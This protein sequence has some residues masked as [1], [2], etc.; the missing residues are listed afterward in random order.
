M[1][2]GMKAVTDVPDISEVYLG[3][4]VYNGM[5]R[6][7]E[8]E[9]QL[10]MEAADKA[11]SRILSFADQTTSNIGTL[12]TYLLPGY[13][14]LVRKY[15]PFYNMLTK[16]VATGLTVNYNALTAYPAGSMLA[17][18]ASITSAAGTVVN[19]AVSVRFGYMQQTLSNIAAKIRS[20][21]DNFTQEWLNYGL[22]GLMQL[23]ESQLLTGDGTAPNMLGL[24]SMFDDATANNY[25]D[26][27]AASLT[28]DM[29]DDAIEGIMSYQ[30]PGAPL[31]ALTDAGTMKQLA[32]LLRPYRA[33]GEAY[34]WREEWATGIEYNGVRFAQHWAFEGKS[35]GSKQ[36]LIFNPD[37]LE[38]HE[39][40]PPVTEDLG[41]SQSTDGR[42]FRHKFYAALADLSA[43]DSTNND[44]TKPLAHALID[45]LA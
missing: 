15:A 9:K 16:K 13:Q 43:S 38:V 40:S 31:Y 37:F 12:P 24:V 21:V 1:E 18:G 2:I 20:G 41:I 44:G 26:A 6:T 33:D 17:E 19:Q 5:V 35:T 42:M 29:I 23:Y 28:L 32:K 45:N 7:K 34:T 10:R 3:H 27:S 36:L 14:D 8:F 11:Y 39:L 4:E 22:K 25:V 30:F